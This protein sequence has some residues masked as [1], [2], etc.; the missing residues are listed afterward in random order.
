MEKTTTPVAIWLTEPASVLLVSP[1]EGGLTIP[2]V[3]RIAR[4]DYWQTVGYQR[5]YNAQR[6]AGLVSPVEGLQL[7]I[8]APRLLELAHTA[9]GARWLIAHPLLA[10]GLVLTQ[11][12]SDWLER[13]LRQ[14]FVDPADADQAAAYV[15][16]SC[17]R[18]QF[19]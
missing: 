19:G 6:Q 3:R 8:H 18:S 13:D 2:Y 7:D 17:E 12:G 16:R 9:R 5:G 15:L 10:L 1:G 14:L 11:G 4:A